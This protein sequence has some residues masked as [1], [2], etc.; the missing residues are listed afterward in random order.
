LPARDLLPGR[1]VV[2]I[3]GDLIDEIADH[4][5]DD[6]CSQR[7]HLLLHLH[8]GQCEQRDEEDPGYYQ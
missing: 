2:G 5:Q 6:A 7:H 3:G 1:T 8:H 4:Q